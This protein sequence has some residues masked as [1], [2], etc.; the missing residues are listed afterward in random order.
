MTNEEFIAAERKERANRLAKRIYRNI[1]VLNEL[2][3]KIEAPSKLYYFDE[4]ALQLLLSMVSR[5][6]SE[7][8]LGIE[9]LGNES[10]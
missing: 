6:L 9:D 3:V 2:C 5:D 1:K 4:L 10:I 8:K 7:I